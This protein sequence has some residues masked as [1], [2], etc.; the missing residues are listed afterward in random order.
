MEETEEDRK[1]KEDE[2][3]YG[4]FWILDRLVSEEMYNVFLDCVEII[5]HINPAVQQDIDDK[6]I[7][8]AMK[9]DVKRG[10]E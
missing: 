6:I 1:K 5:R 9:P 8:E 3:K 7:L 2:A 4:R 10:T